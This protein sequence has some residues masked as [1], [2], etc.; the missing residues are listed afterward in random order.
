MSTPHTAS[1]RR[2]VLGLQYN[3]IEPSA[4]RVAGDLARSLDLEMLAVL[5]EDRSIIDAASLP[6]A[7]EFRLPTHDW[8]PADRRRLALDLQVAADRIHRQL[9]HEILATGIDCRFEVKTGDPATTILAFIGLHDI[10][11]VMEP[12]DALG[13]LNTITERMREAALA[14]EASVLL[15]PGHP[16]PAGGPVIALVAGATDPA[17][18]LAASIAARSA[19]DL[20]VLTAMPGADLTDIARQAGRAVGLSPDKVELATLGS[21]A[22]IPVLHALTGRRGQFLVMS[23]AMSGFPP[24]GLDDLSAGLGIPILVIEAAQ[25]TR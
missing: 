6:F 12:G 4:L 3:H 20:V 14:S 10:V 22:A 7:R 25:G 18:S 13:R 5:V 17:L 21:E 8:H 24:A 11:A 16:I 2:L 19:R 15:L 9:A 23:R 1:Y